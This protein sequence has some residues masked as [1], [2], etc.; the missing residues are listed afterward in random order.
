MRSS[1][2]EASG[3]LKSW[4]NTKASVMFRFSCG[5]LAQIRSP[6]VPF[7]IELD[8]STD[9]MFLRSEGWS[10]EFVLSFADLETFRIT[11]DES[12]SLAFRF[13]DGDAPDSKDIGRLDVFPFEPIPGR[14]ELVQ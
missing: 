14:G 11:E 9:R 13:F 6:R 4:S 7:C 5:A 12:D 10:F 8:E 1:S 2:V 3:V